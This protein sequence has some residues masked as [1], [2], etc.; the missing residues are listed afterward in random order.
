MN[1]EVTVKHLSISTHLIY[2]DSQNPPSFYEAATRK[3]WLSFLKVPMKHFDIQY[4]I[5]SGCLNGETS[6][7]NMYCHFLFVTRKTMMAPS[8]LAP[9]L[10]KGASLNSTHWKTFVISNHSRFSIQNHL[11][12]K[13]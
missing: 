5:D 2:T 8:L 6:T 12:K 11:K 4:R 9:V 13:H 1:A 10:L 3:S 7:L